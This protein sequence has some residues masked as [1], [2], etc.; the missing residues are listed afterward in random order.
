MVVAQEEMDEVQGD[1][2]F[3]PPYVSCQSVENILDR[4]RH[5]G[6]PARV[7]RSYLGSWSGSSQAQFL[8]A[9]RALDLLDAN[10]RPTQRLK[11]LAMR[12]DDRPALVRQMLEE[13]YPEVSALGGNATQ[14]MLEETFRA[15]KGISGTTVRKAVAFY[16]NAA[17]FAKMPLSPYFRAA[18]T[19]GRPPSSTGTTR[20]RPR[21][22]AS[23][24]AETTDLDSG[25]PD[26]RNRHSLREEY[27]AMLMERARAK[28]E[29]DPDLFDRIQQEI[30]KIEPPAQ[31]A[32]TE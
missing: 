6:V 26:P 1:G 15:Y 9:A 25:T 7:D 4:M 3:V 28:Q 2:E 24:T 18:R 16:L 31:V 22:P 13:C 5:A 20:R 23:T 17:R 27:I 8:K 19:G 21:K 30:D 29:D 14:Q 10:G 11:D 12:P 32:P